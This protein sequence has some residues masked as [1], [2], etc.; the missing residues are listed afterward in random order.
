MHYAFC[1]L[2][3]A[4]AMVGCLSGVHEQRII[5]KNNTN[6]KQPNR[7]SLPL[8]LSLFFLARAL[9]VTHGSPISFVYRS[10][11]P[12]SI[13][14]MC[15]TQTLTRSLFHHIS[16]HLILWLQQFNSI[17]Q[18]DYLHCCQAHQP[19]YTELRMISSIRQLNMKNKLPEGKNK[20]CCSG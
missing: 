19:N 13:R 16:P 17:M 8:S 6:N 1:P 12:N 11:C 18:H 3:F 10:V 5:K 9:L 4:I 7:F 20:Y 14:L 15:A 2:C